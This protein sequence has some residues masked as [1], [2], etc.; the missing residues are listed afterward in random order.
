MQ[1]IIIK[2]PGWRNEIKKCWSGGDNSQTYPFHVG[3]VESTGFD[4]EDINSNTYVKAYG[5]FELYTRKSGS[6]K[7]D[8][9]PLTGYIEENGYKKFFQSW[10]LETSLGWAT[11][12]VA[13]GLTIK[14]H[15]GGLIELDNY[16][17]AGS[18]GAVS[19]AWTK[20]FV[21]AIE[22]IY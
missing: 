13:I 11:Q 14:I 16:V 6:E 4:Y 19:C 12:T 15:K 10:R 21:E 7:K 18:W 22:I 17:Y 5:D 3:A 9:L 8:H 20:A 1:T 2:G